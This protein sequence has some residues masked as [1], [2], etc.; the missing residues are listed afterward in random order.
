MGSLAGAAAAWYVGNNRAMFTSG[1]RRFT[2]LPWA[3]WLRRP[4]NGTGEN[5]LKEMMN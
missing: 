4:M 1:L 5:V 2:D 3:S